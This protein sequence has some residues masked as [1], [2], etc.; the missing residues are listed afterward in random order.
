MTRDEYKVMHRLCRLA[1]AFSQ[2]A[3]GKGRAAA[4]KSCDALHSLMCEQLGPKSGS[5]VLRA[6]YQSRGYTWTN[7]R[8]ADRFREL[9]MACYFRRAGNEAV[10]F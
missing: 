3:K 7:W 5:M 4:R 10:P 8:R 2:K 9:K 6:T 1:W